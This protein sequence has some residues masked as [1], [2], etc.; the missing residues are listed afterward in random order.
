VLAF[1]SLSTLF[2]AE[3]MAGASPTYEQM[4]DK[5]LPFYLIWTVSLGALG[6]VAFIGMNAL[7]VQHDITF[8]PASPRL[9]TLRIVLGAVFGLVLTLP[10]GFPAFAQFLATIRGWA[11]DVTK[12]LVLGD[13]IKGYMTQALLLLLPFVL[14]FSTSL[15]IIVLNRFVESAQAFFGRAGM[16]EPA[17]ASRSSSTRPPM[18]S[19]KVKQ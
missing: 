7:S 8:D 18:Q 12:G 19:Q 14:G 11:G 10:F 13:P 2:I 1:A 4:Y 17:H 5:I 16:S 3:R 9:M 15:V 6:S